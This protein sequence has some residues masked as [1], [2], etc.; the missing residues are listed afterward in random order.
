MGFPI[1]RIP[2]VP[3][4]EILRMLEFPDLISIS[5]CSQRCHSVTKWNLYKLKEWEICVI[6][7]RN[8]R[9]ILQKGEEKCVILGVSF[10]ESLSERLSLGAKIESNGIKNTLFRVEITPQGYLTSYWPTDQIGMLECGKYVTN[11]FQKEIH[12]IQFE[13]RSTWLMDLPAYISQKSVSK[14]VFNYCFLRPVEMNFLVRVFEECS[15]EH[16][17]FNG[18]IDKAPRFI[19]FGSFRNFRGGCGIWM[20]VR[21]V[22]NLKCSHISIMSSLW[23]SGHANKFLRRWIHG[24]M[25]RLESFEISIE[26]DVNIDQILDGLDQFVLT[27]SSRRD[28]E[29]YDSWCTVYEL[30]IVNKSGSIALIDVDTVGKMFRMS[31]H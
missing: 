23:N 9:I 8:P 6:R 2:S 7:D 28:S 29:T 21:H 3:F 16:L 22:T 20:T 13:N 27:K 10:G 5:F 17:Q 12:T 19:R 30:E 15:S 31:V 4:R 18:L 14:V 24:G 26:Y 11:L 1:L 25:P